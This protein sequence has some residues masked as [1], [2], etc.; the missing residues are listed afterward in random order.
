MVTSVSSVRLAAGGV[1]DAVP[2]LA[3]LGAGSAKIALSE[4]HDLAEIPTGRAPGVRY[5]VRSGQGPRGLVR[6]TTQVSRGSP[7]G[8]PTGAASGVRVRGSRT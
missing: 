3:V 5:S 2:R 1:G 8:G 7:P 4:D 6:G